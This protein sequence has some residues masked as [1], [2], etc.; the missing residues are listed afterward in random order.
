[1]G[2]N[3][4]PHINELP[5]KEDTV[6]GNDVWIGHNA[7]ILPGVKIGDGAIIGAY[8][9]VAKDIPPYAVAV[10]NPVK[11]VKYRFDEELISLLLKYKWWNKE[12]EEINKILP[13]L[14]SSDLNYVKS[15]LK[16]EINKNNI[17]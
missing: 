3:S 13:I 2:K 8:S 12:E 6:I 1:M 16:E 5:H 9:V 4:T 10:G 7:T 17:E 15:F 11:I 14:T